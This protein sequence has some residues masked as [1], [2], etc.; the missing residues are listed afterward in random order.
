MTPT[1]PATNDQGRWWLDR[2]RN[3]TS[4]C[5]E[6]GILEAIFEIIPGG[7]RWACEFGAWDGR[8]LSNTHHLIAN[9][10]WS[11]VMIEVDAKRTVDLRATYAGNPQVACLT[12]LVGFEGKDTLD[13]ILAGT[14]I[15]ID[16]DLLSIDIDGNDY[17]VWAAVRK[18]SPKVVIIEFNP[19]IPNDIEFVQPARLEVSQGNSLLSLT[20][21]A[22]DKG[23]ELVAVTDLNGIFVRREYFPLFGIRDNSLGAMRPSSPYESKV[24]QLFDGTIVLTGC[25]KLVWQNVQIRQES[26][27]VM[28]RWLRHFPTA[29]GLTRG[30]LQWVWRALYRSRVL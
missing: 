25:T 19:T 2:A 28:P 11:A 17:H 3:V 15:P 16:F 29:F 4:Q 26:I 22:Q 1:A 7:D 10:R 23:Y 12:R 13:S 18:Y 8:Y 9:R 21:L 24:F 27:Q 14:P 5:G 30:V 20:R 6:D